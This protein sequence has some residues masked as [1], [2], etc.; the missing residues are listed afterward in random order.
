[1]I[2][3]I[4]L[5]IFTTLM[6]M[7]CKNNGH[8]GKTTQQTNFKTNSKKKGT[9]VQNIEVRGNVV[10][11]DEKDSLPSAST[12]YTNKKID[13]VSS[14]KK[15]FKAKYYYCGKA[16]TNMKLVNFIKNKNIKDY[17]S[18]KSINTAHNLIINNDTLY[19]QGR[20][21]VKC[22]KRNDSVNVKSTIYKINIGN[23]CFNMIIIDDIEKINF[24]GLTNYD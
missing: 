20:K 15:E 12:F 24:Y 13:S 21:G 8:T 18:L 4:K 22:Y 1:M 19:I 6:F 10:L 11:F 17:Y 23:N 3:T 9:I 2:K 14:Y 7:S 16:H 5:M